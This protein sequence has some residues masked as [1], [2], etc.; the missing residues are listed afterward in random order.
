MRNNNLGPAIEISAP[1]YRP[2][3]VTHVTGC[4]RCG[5]TC[6]FL[7]NCLVCLGQLPCARCLFGRYV[8]NDEIHATLVLED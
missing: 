3:V 7:D 6:R 2:A 1:A 5:S 4:P 8:E